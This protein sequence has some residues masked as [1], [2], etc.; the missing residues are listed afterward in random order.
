MKK[1]KSQIFLF[2]LILSIVI[3]VITIVLILSNFSFKK[4]N[5][6]LFAINSELINSLTQTEINTLN[7]ERIRRMFV[8]KKIVNIKNTIAQ[9]IA[10]FH[11]RG[12]LGDAINL[13]DVFANGYLKVNLNYNIT[14][15]NGTD[16]IRLYEM[17]ST[18]IAYNESEIASSL[19][20]TVIGFY[21]ETDIFGPYTFRIEIWS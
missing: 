5:Q 7:D 11:Y 16:V 3:L 13:S 14:M 17:Q 1:N 4:D 18:N 9:Q 21:N 20:R 2:D 15:E 6:D 8:D 19:K 10:E 12:M